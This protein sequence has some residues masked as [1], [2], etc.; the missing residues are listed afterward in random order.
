MAWLQSLFIC[1]CFAGSSLATTINEPILASMTWTESD[2]FRLIE[3][4]L[5]VNDAS[6]VAVANF[7]NAINA[8]GWSYLEVKTFPQFPDK[9]QVRFINHVIDIP[10]ERRTTQI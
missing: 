2:G 4:K 3:G 5:N 8:T 9:V 6:T 1:L 7:T 10:F